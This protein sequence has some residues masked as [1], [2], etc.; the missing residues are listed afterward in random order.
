MRKPKTSHRWALQLGLPGYLNV[1]VCLR[2]DCCW[3][4]IRLKNSWAYGRP[5]RMFQRYVSA[6]TCGS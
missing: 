6:P 2:P 5:G 1:E 3:R 4:R